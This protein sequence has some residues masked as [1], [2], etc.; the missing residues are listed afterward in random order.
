ME[1]SYYENHAIELSKI[2]K[3]EILGT[4]HNKHLMISSNIVRISYQ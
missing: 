4:G 2:S 1:P 3:M